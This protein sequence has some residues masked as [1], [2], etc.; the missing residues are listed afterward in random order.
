MLFLAVLAGVPGRMTDHTED[1]D[2]DPLR[3]LFGDAWR[4]QTTNIPGRPSAERSAATL[5]DAMA[6]S[7]DSG[8]APRFRTPER[9]TVPWSIAAVGAVC[10]AALL[11]LLG[12]STGA[13]V[14]RP[15]AE[16]VYAT[17][18][19]QRA[20]VTLADGSRVTLAPGT[21]LRV[22]NGFGRTGRDVSLSGE[23]YFDVTHTSALPFIVHTGG[24]STRVLGTAFDI[25]HY[26]GDAGTRVGVVAGRVAVSAE[27]RH[28]PS[29]IVAAG[30]VGTVTDSVGKV[31][32]ADQAPSSVEW[33]TGK[34][35]FNEAPVAEVLGTLAHWYGFQFRLADSA[36]SS[37]HITAAMEGASSAS[38]LHTLK[39]V[40]HVDMTFDG[41]VVTLTPHRETM[42]PVNKRRTI[43]HPFSTTQEVGR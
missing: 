34:L 13:P 10:G 38:A 43:E 18:T 36:L 4:H 42:T 28:H 30:F 7:K 12:R 29:I 5:R 22:A 17:T 26:P 15:T 37:R 19:A 31:T 9:R 8:P 14:V 25:R 32:T 39:L 27:I 21:T 3:E 11:L 23:A 6:A 1:P 33:T 2:R 40:L 16:R 20:S 41:N 24:A 35:V